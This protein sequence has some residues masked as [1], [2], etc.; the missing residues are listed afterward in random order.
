[1]YIYPRESTALLARL[2][3]TPFIIAMVSLPVVGC[4]YVEHLATRLALMVAATT[5]FVTLLSLLT[6][7]KTVELAVAGAT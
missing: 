2:F 5:L 7:A 6:G 1:V 4:N 3:L